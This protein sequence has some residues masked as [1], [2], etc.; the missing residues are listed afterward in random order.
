MFEDIED[1]FWAKVEKLDDGCWRWTGTKV[2]G[3]GQVAYNGKFY[4]AHR[5]AWQLKHGPIPKGL[6]VCHKCDNRPCCNPDHLFLGTH[7]ENTHD[8]VKKGRQ[9]S[10]LTPEAVAVIR[11]ACKYEIKWQEIAD[12]FGI[13]RG[14]I[15]HII[16][17]R[18]W[19][20]R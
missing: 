7:K 15:G 1:W 10:K 17:G 5:I 16:H 6:L 14:N 2:S 20:N 13:T 12:Y 3:Y 8:M 18:K 4:R 9:F 19:V 11:H